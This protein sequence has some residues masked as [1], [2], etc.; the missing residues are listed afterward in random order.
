MTVRI[1]RKRGCAGRTRRE[2]SRR[3]GSDQEIGHLEVH[4]SAKSTWR[5][6]VSSSPESSTPDSVTDQ[7]VTARH[8]FRPVP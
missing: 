1:L 8:A 2:T 7:T 6:R 5:R 4:T 3:D